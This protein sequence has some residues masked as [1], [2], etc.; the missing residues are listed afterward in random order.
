MR[1]SLFVLINTKP[2]KG[3]DM[4]ISLEE[5]D[6]FEVEVE[7]C[8]LKCLAWRGSESAF[9][10]RMTCRGKYD[11]FLGYC[12][13]DILVHLCSLSPHMRLRNEHDWKKWCPIPCLA[14]FYY[15]IIY[16][17]G[18]WHISIYLIWERKLNNTNWMAWFLS[19]DR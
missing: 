7:W 1:V 19:F 8:M 18:A 12:R 6:I 13:R 4:C 5:C 15:H 14:E 9:E 10:P 2:T 17:E 11:L 3:F 16:T